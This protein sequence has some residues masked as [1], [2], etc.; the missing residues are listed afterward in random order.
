MAQEKQ[1]WD[2]DQEAIASAQCERDAWA[3]ID[4]QISASEGWT[5]WTG[6]EC[7]VDP[8]ALVNWRITDEDDERIADTDEIVSHAD[9]LRWSHVGMY[10]IIAYRLATPH[11]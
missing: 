8:D 9:R 2:E 10:D 3:V 11:D 5:E 7:P 6:G 4:A 1:V